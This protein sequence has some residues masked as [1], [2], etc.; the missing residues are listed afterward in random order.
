VLS[1]AVLNICHEY[2]RWMPTAFPKAGLKRLPGVLEVE[3]EDLDPLSVI[4]RQPVRAL[5]VAGGADAISP[6][7]DVRR[8]YE[9]AKPT[10]EFLL[11]PAATHETLPYFFEDL[12]AP[13]T[14]WLDQSQSI[15]K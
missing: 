3:P 10:S 15:P 11:V 5:F 12:A 1:N 2:A 14:Q 4:G 8:L 6:P 7:E 13:V 9:R